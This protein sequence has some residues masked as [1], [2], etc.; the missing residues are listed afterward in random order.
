MKKRLRFLFFFIKY[1]PFYLCY[2]WCSKDP[3]IK[4][5]MIRWIEVILHKKEYDIENIIE[6]F[7]YPEYRSVLYKR[8]KFLSIILGLFYKPQS[9][10]FIC[11]KNSNIQ[12]G[13]VIQHGFSSEI[14]AEFIGKNCQIWQNVTIGVQHSGMN[15]KPI[16]GDD[17]K[18]CTGAIVVGS[19]RIGNNVTIGAGTVVTKD[20]PD[21]SVIYGAPNRIK[22]I[23]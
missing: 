18:I 15:D 9:L 10:L 23:N 16:I 5:D 3:I 21:N 12:S 7:R 2:K 17:C 6:V 22:M 11:T 4:S 1:L 13:F 20:V 8:C 19:I 14:N